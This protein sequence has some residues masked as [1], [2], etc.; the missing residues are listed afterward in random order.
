MIVDH[1]G[2]IATGIF[3]TKYLLDSLTETGHAA[4][5]YAMVTKETFPGW[6]HMLA[7]GATTVWE[8][9]EYSDNTYSHNHPM[10][11]SVSE[12]FFKGL[13]GIKPHP[14]AVGFSR[15]LI[16]PHVVGDLRWAQARY[17]SVRGPVVSDWGIVDGRLSLEVEIPVNATATI[18]VPTPDPSSVTEGGR[19]AQLAP[20]VRA[21]PMDSR[22]GARFEVGSGRYVFAAALV[23]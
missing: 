3:G 15:I 14:Q 18:C 10:F 8:H 22:G 23:L 19:P 13:G 17:R 11:G 12:W 5:A 2:H 1:K 9:W 16:E 21:L 7:R 6:G 4:E 20:G